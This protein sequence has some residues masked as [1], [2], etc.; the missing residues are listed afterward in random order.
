MAGQCGPH[1]GL[2]GRKIGTPEALKAVKGYK[3]RSNKKFTIQGTK[4]KP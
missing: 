4:N 2:H 3:D 1:S